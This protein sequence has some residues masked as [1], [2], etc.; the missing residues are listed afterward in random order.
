MNKLTLQTDTVLSACAIL[1]AFVSI[2]VSVW[3]GME[4]RR[5][6]RLSVRP[7]LELSFNAGKDHFGYNVVNNGLGP[8]IITGL[9]IRLDGIAIRHSGFN[10]FDDFLEKMQLQ[11]RLLKKSAIDSGSTLIA[12][13][14]AAIF[15]CRFEDKDDREA[16]LKNVFTRVSIQLNYASMYEERFLCS[17]P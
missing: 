6:N 1:I 9:T 17:I 15:V 4:T 12:G 14:N 16:I 3:G 7:K 10:G 5:H 2:C 11:G 13:G 8:A